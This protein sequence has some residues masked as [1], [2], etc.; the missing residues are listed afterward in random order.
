MMRRENLEHLVTTGIIKGKHSRGKQCEKKLDGRTKWLK[1]GRVK[2]LK[3]MRNREAWK[4]MIACVKEHGT[5]WIEN[6]R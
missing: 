3:A 5:Y 6:M 4:I 2:A 1:V